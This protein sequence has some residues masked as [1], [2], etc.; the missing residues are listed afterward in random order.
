[1]PKLFFFVATNPNHGRPAT[2]FRRNNGLD[3]PCLHFPPFSHGTTVS[4]IGSL[5]LPESH[6]LT[7]GFPHVKF[8]EATVDMFSSLLLG[9]TMNLLNYCWWFRN[10]EQPPGPCGCIN[11]V[12]KGINL[13]TST[14]EKTTDFWTIN[15]MIQY[16]ATGGMLNS[17][18]LNQ[19]FSNHFL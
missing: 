9:S 3:I 2:F 10:P 5:R 15:S 16:Y 12:N 8:S 11:P 14:G 17:T 6:R 19:L 1:M 18:S 7:L 4:T 13:P